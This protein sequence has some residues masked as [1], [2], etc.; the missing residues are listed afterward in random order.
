MN[1]KDKNLQFVDSL[2]PQPT[3]R[4]Q[5]RAKAR[6]KDWERKPEWWEKN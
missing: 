4:E 2:E 3:N 6:G 1:P 5:K